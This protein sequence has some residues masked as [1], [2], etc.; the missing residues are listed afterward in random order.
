MSKVAIISNNAFSLVNFRT[1]FIKDLV[2]NDRKVYALAPD[3]TD[4]ERKH[5]RIIGAEPVDYFMDRT[6]Q[7]AFKDVRSLVSL[8]KTLK[9]ITPDISF[10]YGIK[11]VVYGLWASRLANVDKRYAM[12]AGLGTLYVDR[13]NETLKEKGRKK[14]ADY[15]Y[16]F[17]LPFADK[18]FFQNPDDIEL[19]TDKNII[20]PAKA[21]LIKGS[22]V[23]IDHYRT[24][25]I[26]KDPLRF[27]LVSRL[28]KE[29]GI[30]EFVEAARIIKSQY[31]QKDIKFILLGGV[32]ANLNS[33]RE[34]ELNE[35][36]DDEIIE[37]PGHVDDVKGWLEKTSVF[38]LP[39]YYREGTPKSILEAMAMGRPVITTDMP[40]C[41]EAVKHQKN[42][43]LIE[44]KNVQQ[45]VDAMKQFI[46]N[47][48]LIDTYG[49]ES[50]KMAVAR[51]DV[52]EV[53]KKILHTIGISAGGPS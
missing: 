18:V 46:T 12:V 25:H 51:Y 15:L 16:K 38:V 6:G 44:P 2:A 21:C 1:H 40:G 37:W 30:Y 10:S 47:T 27:T 31:P 8:V 49:K 42:G 5:I 14:L 41:R 48:L 50:R 23:D 11:P 26:Q 33:V 7:N 22:G 28:I 20:N 35:W 19:F 53:N 45:L 43:V 13:D 9:K 4:Y 17:S 3:F 52:K 36:V 32:D 29:K 34:A 39:T 24:N